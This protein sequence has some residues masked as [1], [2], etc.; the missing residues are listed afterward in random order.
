MKLD[1]RYF[2]KDIIDIEYSKFKEEL[3][4]L[5]KWVLKAGYGVFIMGSHTFICGYN[6][7]DDL[8]NRVDFDESFLRHLK[9]CIVKD[10]T[11]FQNFFFSKFM[12]NFEYNNVIFA[13]YCSQMYSTEQIEIVKSID[14]LT[15]V[16]SIYPDSLRYVMY[17]DKICYIGDTFNK[18][19]H[20]FLKNYPNDRIGFYIIDGKIVYGN[21]INLIDNV[22]DLKMYH[23]DNIFV[24]ITHDNGMYFQR[25]IN[26]EHFLINESVINQ[27]KITGIL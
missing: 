7:E 5:K 11:P 4:N 3:D 6:E 20:L 15:E 16:N 9:M 17:N 26:V 2:R 21:E 27:L 18:G 19:K 12:E 22:N 14:Y 1:K 10:P 23:N 25:D 8:F 24:N 13:P